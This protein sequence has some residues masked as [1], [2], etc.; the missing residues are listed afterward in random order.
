ME[1]FKQK[2][3][4]PLALGAIDTSGQHLLASLAYTKADDAWV[5]N[6]Q[7]LKAPLDGAPYLYAAQ[8]LLDWVKKGY[9]NKDSTGMRQW[10]NS[11][12]I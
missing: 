9:I 12:S 2:G 7:G 4:T 6:Y 11:L 10:R 8:T 5:Q 1:A 3:L